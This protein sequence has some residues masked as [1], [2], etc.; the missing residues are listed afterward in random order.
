MELSELELRI[1][2]ELEEAGE[3]NI[4]SMANTIFPPD[5]VAAEVGQIQKAIISLISADLVRMGE[6]VRNVGVQQLPKDESLVSAAMISQMM[7]FDTD[8]QLWSC[9]QPM[10]PEI[11]DTPSGKAQA[12]QILSERGYQW[13]RPKR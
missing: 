9:P 1:L 7:I 11:T 8:R 6:R 2:S 12:R 3:E 10:W 5:G 4:C 13:W